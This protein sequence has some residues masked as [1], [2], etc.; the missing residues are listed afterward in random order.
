MKTIDGSSKMK[1][2]RFT[3]LMIISLVMM[4][5]CYA[6]HSY[7]TY[8]SIKVVVNDSAAIEYGSANYDVNKLIKEI[9]GEIISVKKDIDTSV[10]GAQEMV[11]EVKKDNIIKDVPIIVNVVD[12]VAPVIQLKEEKMT[13]TEGDQYDLNSN[14]EFVNDKVD[15]DISLLNE[16]EE[17]SKFYYNIST[18]E[19]VN[20]VG[21]HVITVIAKDK[22]G[23]EVKK[24]FTLEIIEAPK[25]EVVPEVNNN[26][27]GN[28]EVSAFNPNAGINAQGGDITSIAYSLVGSP[29]IAGSNGPYGFDCSG[30]V[31]YVYA[32]AG[33]SVSRS[34][35]TQ[36]YEGVGISYDQAQPGDILSWGYV[37]GVPT[38]SA[39]YV[40]NGQM[41]HATNPRQGVIA[42]DVAA[43]TRG[44]GSHV[45]AVR[46]VQ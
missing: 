8:K 2:L 14:I 44:S 15:G 38:H 4:I 12:T 32:Q 20:N 30:F 28:I 13:I 23:N 6:Y 41:V 42:S 34:S 22:S 26:T 3:S 18:P 21:N 19:D 36:Y 39:I 5:G 7:Y 46:R 33:K 31:Q 1:I 16:V 27:N 29:Y 25:V 11:V 45:I 24:E 10:V 43:W 9:D 17:S 40:G 35:S 37:D